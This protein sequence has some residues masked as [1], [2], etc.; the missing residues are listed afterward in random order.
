MTRLLNLTRAQREFTAA[1]I[2]N[3]LAAAIHLPGSRRNSAMHP[4]HSHIL[5][6]AAIGLILAIAPAGAETDL[7]GPE[8][9]S[10][11]DGST[12]QIEECLGR[13]TKAWDKRMN[14]AYQELLKG[15]PQAESL[16]KAQRLWVRYRDVNCH[17]YGL[18]EG[19]IVRVQAAAC[20]RHM[21]AQRAQEFEELLQGG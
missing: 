1:A 4:H 17:Y 15:N 11:A 18:G 19:T 5:A 10:C 8:H 2:L 16:R 3:R 12:P 14:A 20:L 9:Q 13:Y 7:Y 21:T 6:V